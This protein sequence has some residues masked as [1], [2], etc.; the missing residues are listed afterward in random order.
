MATLEQR[1]K[2]ELFRTDVNPLVMDGAVA[3]IRAGGKQL[4][5]DGNA[6]SCF[7][8]FPHEARELRD[9]LNKVLP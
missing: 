8:F 3:F 9:W 1:T 5:I 7:Q 2:D 6:G 4:D